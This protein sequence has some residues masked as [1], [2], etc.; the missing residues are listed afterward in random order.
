M[1]KQGETMRLYSKIYKNT[2]V[3]PNN[4]LKFKKKKPVNASVLREA[5]DSLNSGDTF[6]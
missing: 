3:D 4:F 1:Q 5:R 2:M 6:S